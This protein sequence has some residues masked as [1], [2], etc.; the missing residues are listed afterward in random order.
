MPETPNDD[1]PNPSADMP[2]P[3]ARQM[4]DTPTPAASQMA[5]APMADAAG[6]GSTTPS[7]YSY[8]V[9]DDDDAAGAHQ[10]S[11]RGSGRGGWIAAIV[12][13][14]IVPAVI[15]GALVWVFARGGGGENKTRVTAD[16]SNLLNAFSQGR[17]GT[18]ST[19]Y[20]GTL[21]PGYPGDVPVYPG[22]TLVSS[23]LQ[24]SG[25]DAAYLVIYDTKDTREKVASYFGDQ[26]NAGSFQISSG[27][28]NKD[29]TLHQF[30]KT[31]DPNTTGLVLV[32][33][34]TDNKLTTIVE[35]LQ[36]TAGAT[37]ATKKPFVPDPARVLP[38]GYPSDNVPAY[39]DALLIETA[40]QKQSG[41][42]TYAVSYITKD[43]ATD[44]LKFY[45]DKL[46][47][48]ALGL[49]VTDGDASQSTLKSAKAIQFGDDKQTLRGEITVGEF[50][51]DSSYTRI[52]LQVG[53]AKPASTP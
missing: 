27:Q 26:L 13:A 33:Q 18:D 5:E 1:Q 44:V 28:D 38:D 49:K 32:E 7:G 40:F 25:A 20:E 53:V 21:P 52:D 50:A 4:A 24:V 2:S 11:A 29:T 12:L 19:R 6:D 39:N 15:V 45:R 46:G 34:S 3:G 10:T 36:V 42:K 16:V 43:A 41:N 37:D 22:S 17:A 51:A 23:V 48:S 47:A 30:T 14:A 31:D 35:S 9:V 8:T